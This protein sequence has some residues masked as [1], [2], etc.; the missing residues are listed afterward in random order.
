MDNSTFVSHKDILDIS[1]HEDKE[2]AISLYL[3]SPANERE[4]DFATHFDGLCDNIQEAADKYMRGSKHLKAL[5]QEIRRKRDVLFGNFVENKAQTFCLFI[6]G[7]FDKLAEIPIKMKERVVVGSE[8]CTLPLLAVL[9]QFERFALL[10]FGRE[11]ARLY[12]YYLGKILERDTVFHDYAVPELFAPKHPGKCLATETVDHRIDNVYHRHLREVC[13]ILLGSFKKFGF[14]KLILASDQPEIDSIKRH[15]H[16]Q[17]LPR[18]VGEFV[19]DPDD[20][21]PV[22]KEKADAAVTEYRGK[23][24]K[25]RIT[26]LLECHAQKKAVLGVE[27]TLDALMSGGA[28]VLVLSDDFHDA[29]Y[30]CPE[31][32]FAT[33]T[34]SKNGHCPICSRELE[35]QPVLEDYIIEHAFAQRLEVFHILCQKDMLANYRIGALLRF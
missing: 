6:S 4:E 22:V 7:D 33:T 34:L 35:E 12:G 25:T 9:E 26:E 29:G 31:H 21:V 1:E 32:H 2:G 27:S 20:P 30:V 8:F 15:L 3:H 16:S 14:D 11:K 23:K 13:R 24:E 17:L 28:R 10:V 19:A 5:T 18:I